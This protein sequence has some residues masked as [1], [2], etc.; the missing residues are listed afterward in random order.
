MYKIYYQIPCTLAAVSVF[1][2][3]S[4]DDSIVNIQIQ[5]YITTKL[6]TKPQFNCKMRVTEQHKCNYR[7]STHLLSYAVFWGVILATSHYS[8]SSF[9][10]IGPSWFIGH[11]KL[12]DCRIP[13]KKPWSI[14]VT[15]KYSISQEICTWF[16]CA[17]LCCGYAIVHNEYTWS[18]YPYSS[19]LLCWYWGNR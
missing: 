19:G 11:A 7:I 18:I 16:C 5:E 14:L 3:I 2:I 17:L 10:H 1:F 13:V 6:C 9:T 15:S 4:S 12:Y 8:N